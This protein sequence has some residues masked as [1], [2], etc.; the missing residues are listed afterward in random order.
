M[1]SLIDSVSTARHADHYIRKLDYIRVEHDR[2]ILE[3]D[4]VELGRKAKLDLIYDFDEDCWK[5]KND[6]T[7][8]IPEVYIPALSIVIFKLDPFSG[9][10]QP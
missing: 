10:N 8:I 4:I 3:V 1:A 5:I 7:G 2:F 9:F 6:L